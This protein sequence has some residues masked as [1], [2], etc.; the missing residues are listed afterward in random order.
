MDFDFLVVADLNVV[1]EGDCGA[2]VEV[3]TLLTGHTI[4]MTGHLVLSSLHNSF[5]AEI[6]SLLKPCSD[7]HATN[8]FTLLTRYSY[9]N[10]Q[11]REEWHKWWHNK[12]IT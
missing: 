5:H 6:K 4:N 10:G 11:R 1:P 3:C 9:I 2:L 12:N 7:T 8:V